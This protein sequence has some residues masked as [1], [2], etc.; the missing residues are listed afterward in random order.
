MNILVVVAIILLVFL[1]LGQIPLAVG[2]TYQGEQPSAWIQIWGFKLMLLPKKEKKNRAPKEKKPKK[3]AEKDKKE[4]MTIPEILSLVVDLLPVLQRA[5][6]RLYGR[7]RMEEFLLLVT[8]PGQEDPAGSAIRYGQMNAL[9]GAI[10]NPLVEMLHM[11]DGQAGVHVD[12][13]KDKLGLEAKGILSIKLGQLL[14]IVIKLAVHGLC[15][16]L[17]HRRQNKLRKAVS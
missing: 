6:G 16:F 17:Q 4:K 10:W 13:T 11:E 8:I 3:K 7:L 12:F 9:L 1:L 14:V 5:L 2:G 15:I